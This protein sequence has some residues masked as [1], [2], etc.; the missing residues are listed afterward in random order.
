MRA[1]RQQ[2]AGFRPEDFGTL[3]TAMAAFSREYPRGLTYRDIRLADLYGAARLVPGAVV[4]EGLGMLV[5]EVGKGVGTGSL[6]LHRELRVSSA[7]AVRWDDVGRWWGLHKGAA[8]AYCG[9]RAG[10]LCRVSANVPVA[11]VNWDWTVLRALESPET[12]EAA[13][14]DGVDLEIERVEVSRD[15][16]KTWR[17]VRRWPESACTRRA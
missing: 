2:A 10:L 5:R 17:P 9:G 15:E 1:A 6:V 13:L 14:M 7:A 8:M 16:R 11:G 4:R 3:K 12:A